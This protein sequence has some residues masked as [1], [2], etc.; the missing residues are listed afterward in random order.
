MSLA[1]FKRRA[2]MRWFIKFC[3]IFS[4][5]IAHAYEE[6]GHQW[7]IL[8]GQGMINSDFGGYLE[9]QARRSD[10]QDKVYEYLIR[11]AIYYKTEKSGSYFLGTLKRFDDKSHENENRHWLQWLTF[12]NLESF[13]ITSRFRQ[14]FRDIKS[15]KDI[16]HRSRLMLR[17][18]SESF[19]LK[20]SWKPF[21]ASEIFYNW[22]DA[23]T[24]KKGLHQSRNS[25]GISNSVNSVLT[26]ETA[27]MLQIL[28]HSHRE[29][30]MNHNLVL[31]LIT[32]L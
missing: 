29:N 25:I 15:I 10:R 5:L 21:V 2:N 20:D 3:I 27:Y 18:T 11:P 22:N 32:Q 9:M 7:V 4:S 28:N 19:T 14:E 12:F 6:D 24:L 1:C 17:A 13:K 31:S 23:G 8:T 16:S 30:Q 26:I